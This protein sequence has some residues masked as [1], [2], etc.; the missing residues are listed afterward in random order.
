MTTNFIQSFYLHSTEEHPL[1][2]SLGFLSPEFHWM[3]WCLSCLQLNRLHGSVDLFTNELGKE[4]LINQL[5]LPYQNVTVLNTEDPQNIWSKNKIITY[6]LQEKPFIHVDGDVFLW[7]KLNSNLLASGLVVQNIESCHRFYKAIVDEMLQHG[8]SFPEVVN[9]GMLHKN[10]SS[11]NAGIIGGND[12]AFFKEYTKLSLDFIE[13]NFDKLTK[14]KNKDVNMVPE[15]LFFYILSKI[16]KK[17]INCLFQDPTT[18]MSYPGIVNFI[19]VPHQTKF[20][21]MLGK[22]K[23]N[24]EACTM[25]AKRLRTDYPDHYYNI[26]NLMKKNGL[27][28]YFS[29]YNPSPSKMDKKTKIATVQWDKLYSDQVKQYKLI[30]GTFKDSSTILDSYFFVSLNLLNG[31]DPLVVSAPCSLNKKFIKKRLDE[32]DSLMIQLLKTPKKIMGL[33]DDFS[34]FIDEE[35]FL[36]EKPELLELLKLKLRRGCE[37]NIYLIKT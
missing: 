35:C 23:K 30:D 22:Y 25:L 11:C 17:E 27:R 9:N 5:K 20:V 26:I 2:S 33:L 13:S 18:S 1:N 15:Q 6:S 8:I 19:D 36:E 29:T 10:I 12:L 24:K 28:S 3:S 31:K 14:T 37:E 34:N 32:V 4:V 16:Q 21:H 7:N